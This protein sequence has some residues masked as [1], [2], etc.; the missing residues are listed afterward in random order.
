MKTNFAALILPY[1][2]CAPHRSS[3]GALCPLARKAFVLKGSPHLPRLK[4]ITRQ[5]IRKPND[6]KEGGRS[7]AATVVQRVW[8][9]QGHPGG[10]A[11]ASGV[12]GTVGSG[13][14]QITLKILVK[15]DRQ[16]RGVRTE[17]RLLKWQR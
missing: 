2:V 15:T 10:S 17:G 11:S 8:R 13:F 3:R 6:N 14:S 12:S 7:W 16:K 4:G 5:D 9:G 1:Q